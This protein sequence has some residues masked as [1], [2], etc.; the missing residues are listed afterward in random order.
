MAHFQ[1]LLVCL[2]SLP[3]DLVVMGD[4]NL[5]L[6]SSSSDVRQLIGI[7]ESFD[8]NQ[9]VNF[10]TNIHSHS[11][12]VMIFSHRCDVLSVSPSDA[13]SDHFCCC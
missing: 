13:I 7:L 8:L 3:H 5:H 12:D 4:F 10:P 2:A 6:K 1:D 9:H 11:L